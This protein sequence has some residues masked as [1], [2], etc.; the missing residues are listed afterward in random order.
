MIQELKIHQPSTISLIGNFFEFIRSF[1]AWWYGDIPL[2]LFALLKRVLLVINDTTSFGVIL[3]GFFRPWKNDYNVAGWLIGIVIKT[4]Y[5]P[6]AGSL[7]LLTIAL[8]LLLLIIQL[9]ILPLII[10]LI[11]INPFL[12]P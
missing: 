4:F 3:S 11:L 5:L 8:F 10:G 6:I 1:F 7:F 2:S 12:R 9:A